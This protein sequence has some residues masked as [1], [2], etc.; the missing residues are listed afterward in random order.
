[1]ATEYPRIERWIEGVTPGTP[2]EGQARYDVN[3][4]EVD[5]QIKILYNSILHTFPSTA[6]VQTMIDTGSSLQAAYNNGN[7]ISATGVGEAIDFSVANSE[8]IPVLKLE[9]KDSSNNPNVLEITNW[10]AGKDI[11]INNV[12][13]RGE[14]R[15]TSSNYTNGL[16]IGIDGSGGKYVKDDD[17]EK[18][19]LQS[20]S[21]SIS[22][23]EISAADE[24]IV[25][26]S[27]VTHRFEVE[28][29]NL[30]SITRSGSPFGTI[31]VGTS[32]HAYLNMSAPTTDRG[33]IVFNP[34][35]GNNPSAPISGELWFNGTSFNF[36]D[37]TTT[38]DLLMSSGI[39][40]LQ[41]AYEGG[42]TIST[43]VANGELTITNPDGQA[44][45]AMKIVQE[46][47]GYY[48]AL[49]I[50]ISGLGHAIQVN[51]EDFVVHN[52][53]LVGIGTYFSRAYLDIHR[54]NAG[55]PHMRLYQSS[56]V[57]PTTGAEG[58][59]WYNGTNLY[60]RG[61]GVLVDLLSPGGASN[62]QQAYDGGSAINTSVASGALTFTNPDGQNQD[63]LTI[64]QEST[65]SYR[66][67]QINNPNGAEVSV[68]LNEEDF[69]IHNG[70]R[71]G[72]GTYYA[73]AYL[74]IQRSTTSYPH[75]Y[76]RTSDGVDPTNPESGF[77]WYNGTNLN[78]RSGT[79]TYDLL[80]GGGGVDNL[81]QAY[82]GGNTINASLS[83]EALTVSVTAGGGVSALKLNQNDTTNNPYA[84]EI[85]STSTGE[86]IHISNT[87][88]SA[89]ILLTTTQGPQGLSLW[90]DG[91]ASG[92]K[93]VEDKD[94]I[95]L[96]VR[97]GISES[98]HMDPGSGTSYN[99][100]D[101]H[102]IKIN[103]SD[104]ILITDA[105]NYGTVS[106]GTGKHSNLSLSASTTDRGQ[107]LLNAGTDPSSPLQG[108]MWYNGTN[109][110]FRN[111]TTTIDLLLGSPK[112]H[113]K[114][115]LFSRDFAAESVSPGGSLSFTNNT[116]YDD[117]DNISVISIYEVRLTAGRKY[118]ATGSVNALMT[119]SDGYMDFRFQANGSNVGTTGS[120]IAATSDG[121][122][123]SNTRAIAILTPTAGDDLLRMVVS[124]GDATVSYA[125]DVIIHELEP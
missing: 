111:G 41:Q 105:A 118:I 2:V 26:S 51:S 32:S 15:M 93:F 74:H 63:A 85:S 23:I 71:V 55:Y 34:G 52:G 58:D 21:A 78:F 44:Q 37:G 110:Y 125:T 121:Q 87:T 106:I 104:R 43:S 107:L 81:Q 8:N 38:H 47:A 3:V 54:P 88:T 56:G 59:F 112:S 116:I 16:G 100:A 50:E 96:I 89:G 46:A 82:E 70:G 30:L 67:L 45:V 84:L 117:S 94:S 98:I 20:T 92:T 61:D 79:T 77:L 75:M 113:E 11:L 97:S 90:S 122:S 19:T 29:L 42:N 115:V 62:L 76:L 24:S 25:H 119:G 9:Q 6:K 109:L 39:S 95:S 80:A 64:N 10:G 123:G 14:I 120:I 36:Y 22:S 28:G 114:N 13:D 17:G 5:A 72:I 33:Q 53:G 99:S 12:T 35:S 103:S 40:N 31:A 86:E 102:G 108:E 73:G 27:A 124:D 18:L 65:G 69:V 49:Q 68:R 66:A 4:P 57:D 83:N 7:S 91:T 101:S 1:M 60:F 48:D